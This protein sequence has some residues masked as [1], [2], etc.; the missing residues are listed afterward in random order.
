MEFKKEKVGTGRFSHLILENSEIF[1]GINFDESEEFQ[2]VLAN[3][4]FEN[5]VL[6]PGDEVVDLSGPAPTD[7]INEKPKQFIVIDGTWPCAKKMMRLSTCLHSIKRASFSTNRRSAFKV[8]HQ[9]LP[10]CLSTVESIHQVILELNRLGVEST[11]GKEENLIQVFSQTVE[12]Q[13]AIAS[14]PQN[15]GYRRSPYA[16]PGQRKASK[17]WEKRLLFFRKE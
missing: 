16:V 14:D 12:L 1:V 4:D 10:Q 7:F 13:L 6:Y 2:K 17:K 15:P 11:Q 3:P 5:Y 9:P 8:K